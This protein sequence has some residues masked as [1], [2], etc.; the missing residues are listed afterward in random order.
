[1][2]VR[3]I[4]KDFSGSFRFDSHSSIHMKRLLGLRSKSKFVRACHFVRTSFYTRVTETKSIRPLDHSRPLALLF[5]HY[6][7]VTKRPLLVTWC[8]PIFL[9]PSEI[10][11]CPMLLNQGDS[12]WTLL[13]MAEDY[14]SR[15]ENNLCLGLKIDPADVLLTPGGSDWQKSI[16]F[17]S[18]APKKGRK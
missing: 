13:N 7:N 12:T 16:G 14:F 3:S 8:V 4:A 18:G 15:K 6:H 2:A 5:Y 17:F 9:V 10:Y 11:F 1:M